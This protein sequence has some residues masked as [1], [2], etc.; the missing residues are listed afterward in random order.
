MKA[1]FAVAIL[2]VVA[3]SAVAAA[4]ALTDEHYEFLFTRYVEQYSKS[5][6]TKS[7]FT[8]Y[9]AFKAN[10]NS[11]LAHN[12]MTNS[13]TQSMNEFGDLSW[14]EFKAKFLTLQAPQVKPQDS[15]EAPIESNDDSLDWRTLGAVTPVK[16][17]GSCGSCWAF[18]ATGSLEG[19]NFNKTGKLLSL[20]EQQLV[21]CSGSTGN[22][23]CRGGLMTKAFQ[24]IQKNN[25]ICLESDY[26]YTAKDESCKTSCKPQVKITGY[27]EIS[28]ESALMNGVNLTPISVAVEVNDG[29][30]FYSKGV[31]DATCGTRLNHGITAVGYGSEAGKPYW[32][33]K[34]SWG[35]SWGEQGYIRLV[36][37]KNQCGV[38]SM[39]CYPT[40]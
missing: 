6:E 1:V 34:N 21:D 9:N 25:G 37:N 35:T 28:N 20:S 31:F 15:F 7:F 19:V 18:S 39:A 11:I 10:L 22:N 29:F 3:V 14:S 24:W 16:N 4:P 33:V 26:A 17:Q 23:G 38:A 36:R 12:A 27:K 5:Y 13:Y 40:M 32:I 2:A 8:R 30:R